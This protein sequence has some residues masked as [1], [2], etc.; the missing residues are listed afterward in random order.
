MVGKGLLLGP[1]LAE[2]WPSR[3]Q[4]WRGESWRTEGAR[5]KRAGVRGETVPGGQPLVPTSG[6]G[7]VAVSDPHLWPIHRSRWERSRVLIIK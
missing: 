3:L 1:D 6:G 4:V 5:G 7:S 2:Q